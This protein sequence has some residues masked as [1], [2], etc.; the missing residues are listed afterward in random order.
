MN[1]GMGSGL[2]EKTKTGEENIRFQGYLRGFFWVEETSLKI[3]EGG[4]FSIAEEWKLRG[5]RETERTWTG[6]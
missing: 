5:K 6:V 1:R 4:L 3:D 2:Q